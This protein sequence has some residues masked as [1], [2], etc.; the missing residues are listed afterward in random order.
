MS[1]DSE[2]PVERPHS[3]SAAAEADTSMPT[4]PAAIATPSALTL[5]ADQLLLLETPPLADVHRDVQK[6]NHQPFLQMCMELTQSS[7]SP[8]ASAAQACVLVVDGQV[9]YSCS[10]LPAPASSSAASSSAS[11]TATA[12]HGASAESQLLSAVDSAS[13]SSSYFFSPSR[14]HLLVVYCR[15]QPSSTSL[16]ALFQCG[17]RTVVFA[18]NSQEGRSSSLPEGM[19]LLGPLLPQAAAAAYPAAIV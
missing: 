1:C 13:S 18:Q 7:S 9:I 8:S 5:T 19:L 6:Q 3:S 14:H 17:I 4:Q 11:S 10:S 12:E 2:V 15:F 16:Q